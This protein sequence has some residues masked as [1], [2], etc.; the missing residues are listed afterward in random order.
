MFLQHLYPLVFITVLSSVDQIASVSLFV[1]WQSNQEKNWVFT[2]F[3]QVILSDFLLSTFHKNKQQQPLI[4][5]N[6]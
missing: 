2:E 1:K 6:N 4:P 3:S 5:S